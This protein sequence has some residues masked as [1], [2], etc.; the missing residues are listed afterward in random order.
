MSLSP[1]SVPLMFCA[2]FENLNVFHLKLVLL[3]SCCR[4]IVGDLYVVLHIEEKRGI[5]RDGLDLFSKVNIDYTEAILG[6]IRKVVT[7]LFLNA[8]VH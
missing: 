2:S 5:Q 6:T 1:L 8:M 3:L 7:I 4:S